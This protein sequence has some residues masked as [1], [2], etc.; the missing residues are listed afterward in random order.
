MSRLA[1][2][3]G[4]VDLLVSDAVMPVMNGRE[5]GDQLAEH[6]PEVPVVWMSGYPRE[7]FSGRPGTAF[8]QK[9]IGTERL[10]AVVGEIVGKRSRS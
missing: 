1:E 5:L 6:Y 10:L 9:P 7:A 4:A 2:L 8:L 3:E